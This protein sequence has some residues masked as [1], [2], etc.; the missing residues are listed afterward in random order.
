MSLL[1]KSLLKEKGRSHF[2]PLKNFKGIIVKWDES[3]LKAGIVGATM[4]NSLIYSGI[5]MVAGWFGAALPMY[6]HKPQKDSRYLRL[7]I[8]LGAGVLLGAAFLHLIPDAID[9]TGKSMGFWLLGGFLFLF[10]LE[11]FTFS[12][13]CEEDHC[14]YHKIGWVA[15]AGLSLHNLVNGVALGSALSIPA[16]GIIVFLATL[17][18]KAPEF[19][20]LSSL[21]IAGKRSK[22]QAAFLIIIVSIMIPLGA[23]LSQVFLAQKTASVLGAALAFSAGTFIHI[24]VVDLVPEI[25]QAKNWRN[26]HFAAFMAGLFLMGLATQW[27]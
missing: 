11:M 9:A 5:V 3:A 14:D 7:F 20:S 8:S 10:L 25:H 23:V 27:E 22:R 26:Y 12:H 2:P 6:F 18:H 16:L 24:A 21:L 4:V 17:G 15:F 19:F 1:S 13:P